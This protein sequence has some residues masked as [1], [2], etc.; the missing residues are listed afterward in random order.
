M[1]VVDR[2]GE[3]EHVGVVIAGL[4]QAWNAHDMHAFA[5]FF[6]GDASFINVRGS[7]LES[8]DQIEASHQAVHNSFYKDSIAEIRPAK[9]RIV[10]PDVAVVQATWQIRGDSRRAGARDYVMTLVLRKEGEHWKILAAQNCSAEDRTGLGLANPRPNDAASL[11]ARSTESDPAEVNDRIRAAIAAFDQAWNDSDPLAM[12]RRFATDSDFVDTAA[13]WL[14]GRHPIASHII[15]VTLSMSKCRASVS[16]SGLPLLKSS[17]CCTPNS[18][19]FCSTGPCKPRIQ[20]AQLRRA[21]AFALSRIW[22]RFGRFL[23]LKTRSSEYRPDCLHRPTLRQNVSSRK[24]C[25]SQSKRRLTVGA[26]AHD[27]T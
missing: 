10:R 18:Q 7:W 16:R 21:W 2:S 14:H 19:L 6:A 13:R 20:R 9:I 22:D 27:L 1:R 17:R 25:Q 11:E 3:S 15:D 8:S 5:E 4:M 26:A 12:A 24:V 23:P